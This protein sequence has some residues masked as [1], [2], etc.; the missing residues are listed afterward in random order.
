MDERKETKCS[1]QSKNNNHESIG[2]L[3][4]EAMKSI[5]QWIMDNETEKAPPNYQHTEQQQT[6]EETKTADDTESIKRIRPKRDVV[7][8]NKTSLSSSLSHLSD[9]QKKLVF[10]QLRAYACILR[11]EGKSVAG[12]F[13]R[14]PTH[15]VYV[16]GAGGSCGVKHDEA[17]QFF[18]Q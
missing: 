17:V 13:S 2:N 10:K 5:Q 9:K 18:S 16:A 8:A 7:A 1:K 14:E 15:C 6:N 12:L 11:A 4:K 3:D